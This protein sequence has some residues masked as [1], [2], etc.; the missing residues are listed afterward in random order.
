M[1]FKLRLIPAAVVA[2]TIAACGGGGGGGTPASNATSG[3]AVDGYLSGATIVCDVDDNGIVSASEL[4]AAVVTD[5]NGKF[6]FP[7]GC[8]HGMI[9]SKGTSA[10]TGLA[11]TGLLKAPKGA[12]VISPLTTL[13]ASGTLNEAALKT[14]LGLTTTT[15]LLNTDP[16][17]LADP[18]LL[19]KTLVIQQLIQKTAELIA[20]L[21]PAAINAGVT[22]AAIYAEVA[23]AVAANLTAGSSLNSATLLPAD[24]TPL[25]SAAITAVNTA[26][27]S[28]GTILTAVGKPTPDVL[29]AVAGPALASQAQAILSAATPTAITAATLDKQSNT[30]ITSV[31]TTAVTDGLLNATS[32][33]TSAAAVATTVTTAAATPTPVPVSK[34]YLY[35]ANNTI[36]LVDGGTTSAYSMADFQSA[37][38]ISVKWPLT[39]LAAVTFTLSENGTAVL[40]SGQLTAAI[41][42][43]DT[44]GSGQVKAYI[45][46]VNVT[47]TGGVIQVTVPT[48]A[49]ALVYAV[50]GSGTFTGLASFTSAVWG[51]N[52]TITAGSLSSLLLGSTVNSTFT[53]LGTNFNSQTA[54]GGKYKVSIVVTNL[55]LRQTDGTPF[56]SVTVV[57]PTSLV[58]NGSSKT[59]TGLGLEGFITLTN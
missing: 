15:S 34:D 44:A 42:V 27:P 45:D 26:I 19:Q 58:S 24:V 36:N 35:L 52:N 41:S 6:T 20:G 17:A 37:A 2:L 31:I 43:S 48:T 55:P 40:P 9:A 28:V 39:N 54:L 18:S 4:A 23:K 32:T 51:A 3:V 16:V 46:N 5:A 38:G 30:T 47:K 11:F 25:V 21:A 10:D 22:P 7:N 49:N 13:L 53:S 57:V 56:K 8:T 50:S 14:A 29:A 12:T 59:V 1:Q 33:T